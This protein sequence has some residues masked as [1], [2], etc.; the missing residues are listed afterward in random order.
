MGD[1]FG[2]VEPHTL[3]KIGMAKDM[4]RGFLFFKMDEKQS[5]SLR[6]ANWMVMEGVIMWMEVYI[7]KAYS[8]TV[9]S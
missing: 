5:E 3:E 1:T 8:K 9:S 2:K 7:V 4:V 6:M